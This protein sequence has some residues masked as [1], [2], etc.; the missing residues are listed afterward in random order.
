MYFYCCLCILI[1][2]YVPFYV[3]FS[4][5]SMYC[6]CVPPAVNTIAGKKYIVSYRNVNTQVLPM[7]RVHTL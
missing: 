6:L 1:V 5:C 3:L 2:M 7:S 4:S